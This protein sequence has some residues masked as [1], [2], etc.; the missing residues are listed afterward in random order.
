MFWIIYLSCANKY[1]Y[2]YQEK[3]Y[4]NDERMLKLLG[5]LKVTVPIIN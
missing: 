1:L 2:K 5:S 4:H 3:N